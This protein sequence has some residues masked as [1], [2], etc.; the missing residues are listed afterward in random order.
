MDKKIIVWTPELG[1]GIL[2]QDMQHKTLIDQINELY[3][4]ILAKK[5]AD[6]ITSIVSFLD[7][8]VVHHFSIEECYM[9]HYR[10]PE[11]ERHVAEHKWFSQNL[12]ELKKYRPSQGEMAAQS[13]CYDLCDWF[14]NHIISIDKRLG[15]L[16]KSSGEK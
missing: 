4:A 3:A 2:W 13:L 7:A 15:D 1:T 14:K 5:G 10:D 9:D 6:Q 11:L 8:Y 16:L 12:A